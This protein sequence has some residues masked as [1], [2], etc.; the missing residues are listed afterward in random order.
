MRAFYE[1][2]AL[3]DYETTD[4]A[5]AVA[6]MQRTANSPSHLD[7]CIAPKGSVPDVYISHLRC[8]DLEDDWSDDSQI[9]PSIMASAKHNRYIQRLVLDDDAQYNGRPICLLGEDEENHHAWRYTNP[10]Q[11][12]DLQ[13]MLYEAA[14]DSMQA[15]CN[16]FALS[17]RM[18]ALRGMWKSHNIIWKNPT[19]DHVFAAVCVRK[20]KAWLHPDTQSHMLEKALIRTVKYT[21]ALEFD[22]QGYH[23]LSFWELLWDYVQ[24]C[25][26][27]QV[28]TML[29]PAHWNMTARLYRTKHLSL[30]DLP[31]PAHEILQQ[32]HHA[33]APV[34][35]VLQTLQQDPEELLRAMVGLLFTRV[36]TLDKEDEADIFSEAH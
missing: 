21:R 26:L 30:K 15:V 10:Q 9:T 36:V 11:A 35:Q 5:Q 8:V 33:P 1:P 32:L 13:T 20:R 25:S 7:W 34:N 24:R 31:H 17:S 18:V 16:L 2:V 29:S 19:D 12:I 22:T 23:E 3:T 28:H 4:I 14:I 6:A 27:T